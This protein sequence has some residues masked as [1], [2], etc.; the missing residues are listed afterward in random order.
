MQREIWT[1]VDAV[2][3]VDLIQ[4]LE[5]MGA[6]RLIKSLRAM[7]PRPVVD[8]RSAAVFL[9]GVFTSSSGG[10]IDGHRALRGPDH[11]TGRA[12]PGR[13]PSAPRSSS[14]LT[15]MT[16]TRCGAQPQQPSEAGTTAAQP[17]LN[18]LILTLMKHPLGVLILRT[19]PVDFHNPRINQ[20]ARHAGLA[21]RGDIHHLGYPTI[22]ACTTQ[23]SR[24]TCRGP[25]GLQ[26]TEFKQR[27]Q[28]RVVIVAQFIL[29]VRT[30]SLISTPPVAL[31]LHQGVLLQERRLGE[32]LLESR[33]ESAWPQCEP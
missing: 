18:L 19:H 23:P 20:S 26:T 32:V 28:C 30:S 7:K 21:I 1:R 17:R 24:Q 25:V 33:C 4:L 2:D 9:M 10:I 3:V 13:R 14:P 22:A 16:T 11:S 6:V 8:H 15:V 27:T 5:T 31:P 12:D 29:M